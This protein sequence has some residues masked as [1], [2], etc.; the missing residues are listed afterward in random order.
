N[1]IEPFLVRD[2]D[3]SLQAIER[4]TLH[5]I[6]RRPAIATIAKVA[7]VTFFSRGLERRD[8][9]SLSKNS[10]GTS[11]QLN[12]SEPVRAQP[13]QA[14]LDTFQKR[15]RRP[16]FAANAA[17]MAALRKKVIVRPPIGDRL[18]EQLF[19]ALIAFAGVD[20]VA[21]GSHG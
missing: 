10:L 17:R 4:A 20:D 8:R 3:R 15:C 16:I 5:S 9:V 7:R 13:A 18:A 12:K 19:A 11:M 14:A 21:P 2:A 6:T 1:E